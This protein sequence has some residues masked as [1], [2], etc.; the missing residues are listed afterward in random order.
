MSDLAL[1]VA[2]TLMFASIAG[3]IGLGMVAWRRQGVI[4]SLEVR[5]GGGLGL[6][7]PVASDRHMALRGRAGTSQ[8]DLPVPSDGR[9]RAGLITAFIA[10]EFSRAIKEAV[11]ESLVHLRRWRD[12]MAAR[13]SASA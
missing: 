2:T 11:P 3:A 8:G 7:A 4:K 9:M 12:A 5:E 1:I 10:V 6:S 13:P